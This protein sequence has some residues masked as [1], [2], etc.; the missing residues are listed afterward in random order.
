MNELKKSVDGKIL[1]R[2]NPFLKKLNQSTLNN[3]QSFEKRSSTNES[4]KNKTK[5][6]ENNKNIE[7]NNKKKLNDILYKKCSVN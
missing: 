2:K 3:N 5:N 4:C 6:D 1:S 7:D